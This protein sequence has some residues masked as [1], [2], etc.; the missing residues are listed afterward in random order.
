[1]ILVTGS[2][3]FIGKHLIKRLGELNIDYVPYDLLL[4]GDITD[5]AALHR[6]FDCIPIDTIIHLAAITRADESCEEKFISTNVTGTAVLLN[7]AEQYNVNNIIALSSSAVYRADWGPQSESTPTDPISLYGI[8]KLAMEL[9]CHKSKIPTIIARPFSVYGKGNADHIINIWLK[10]IKNNE[11][12]SFFGDGSIKRGYV[13][14]EDLVDGIIDLL[15]LKALVNFVTFN[16]GGREIITSQQLLDIFKSVYPDLKVNH[17]PIPDTCIYDS[18][19]DISKARSLLD[20]EPKTN[21]EEKVKE[22]INVL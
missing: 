22:L 10:Q 3:G 12:V 2:E 21:F 4:G 5:K 7:V 18:W 16:F 1:M 8:T 9:L 6:F 11:P 19:P 13:Y 14:V 15:S 17:L 20:W